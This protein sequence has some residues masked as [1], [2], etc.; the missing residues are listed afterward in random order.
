M[1]V[2][3]VACNKYTHVCPINVYFLNKYWPNQ[4]ITILGYEKVKE[5]KNLPSNVNVVCLG[6]EK[7]YGKSWTDALIPYF[8][9]VPEDYF[10]L[11]VE[12][13]ILM[14]EMDLEHIEILEN[15]IRLGRAQKAMISGG[16]PLLPTSVSF[17]EEG[18]SFKVFN[19]GISYRTSL[20]PAIWKK[21]YFLRYLRPD[22]T[23]WDFEM[24]NNHEAAFDGAIQIN[25]DYSFPRDPHTFTILNLYEK[26]VLTI[27][28]SAEILKNC[29]E[30]PEIQELFKKIDLEYI[31]ERI[32][33]T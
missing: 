6:E 18:R 2:Y 25:A 31:W 29:T 13:S 23:C 15:Q 8:K 22:M 10:T 24:V 27:G 20:H 16:L 19:Q 17:D 9:S 14:K 5:L 21:D 28:A 11:M 33:E 7:K 30:E 4:D 26:G 1:K 12:D 32:N 3:I